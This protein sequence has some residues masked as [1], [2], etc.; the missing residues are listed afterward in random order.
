MN[1]TGKI[2]HVVYFLAFHGGVT[3]MNLHLRN[4]NLLS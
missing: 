4:L 3:L 2:K 1:Q